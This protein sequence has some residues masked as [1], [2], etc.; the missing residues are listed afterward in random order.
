M[1]TAITL[2]N[3][4]GRWLVAQL[5]RMSV[6]LAILA[7]IVL[8]A[9]YVL[10]VKSPALRH[11]FWGLLLAKPL[12]TF[13]VAS[14]LSLYAFLW[15]P[16][17]EVFITQTPVSVQMERLPFEHPVPPVSMPDASSSIETPRP[18][19]PPFWRQI[20][21]YGLVSAI[22]MLVASV[23]GLRLLLGCAYVAFLRSTALTQR[24]GPLAELVAEAGSPLRMRRRVRIAT[25]RV[26]HGPVLAGIF[27][28][29]ILLPESMA[30]ALTPKQ[31]KL[32][33]TH[34]LA[35]AKR[36]DNLVLLVQ[37]L[38]EMF[39]F[40]HPVVWLC[41]WMMRR[42]A[43]AACDDM[44][45]SAYGD[46]D[47]AGAAAYADS[48]TRVA[49]MK[50]GITHRLLVNTFAAAESNFNRRIR[51]ILSGRR[52]RM[53][54]WLSVATGVALI[55]IG[56][57]GLPTVSSSPKDKSQE[58][59]AT[60]PQTEA[61]KL[62]AD[63]SSALQGP[64]KEVLLAKIRSQYTRIQNLRV[65]TRVDGHF[66]DGSKPDGSM[67]LTWG[68][69]GE[70]R[71]NSESDICPPGGKSNGQQRI[72]VWNGKMFSNYNSSSNTCYTIPPAE[73][74]KSPKVGA[75]SNY[76]YF[77]GELATE[78]TLVQLFDRIP[79]EKLI[80]QPD[81]SGQLFILSTEAAIPD[82][83]FSWL[84]DPDRGWVVKEVTVELPKPGKVGGYCVLF[85]EVVND[86]KEALPGI[87]LPT[88]STGTSC[89]FEE[90]TTYSAKTHVTR[91][92]VNDPETE[93]LFDF[94][95]PKDCKCYDGSAMVKGYYSIA[96]ITNGL[97]QQSK[98][99]AEGKP[100]EQASDQPPID[101]SAP[102]QT[103][104]DQVYSLKDGEVLKRI[105]PPF[106]PERMDWYRAEFPGQ[107][108]SSPEGPPLC[109]TMSWDKRMVGMTAT[110][111]CD[112]TTLMLEH[113]FQ[114]LTGLSLN[115]VMIPSD[116]LKLEVPGDWIVRDGA[117]TET[118]IKELAR[119]LH[120]ELNCDAQFTK[121]DM[122]REVIVASGAY[123][124]TP[125]P[126]VK[127]NKEI[128]LF[129]DVFDPNSGAG[130]S[131]GKTIPEFLRTFEDRIGQRIIDETT[132][133]A[134]KTEYI[135]FHP[136]KS[137]NAARAK[138]LAEKDGK[139]LERL[140]NLFLANVAKQT[141]FQFRIEQRSVPIW[142]FTRNG[143]TPAAT[144]A[145]SSREAANKPQE[146][147][148]VQ[149]PNDA[150]AS[151]R[152]AFDQVYS[153]KDGEVLKRIAPPFIPERME[154]YRAENPGQAASIPEGP[155]YLAIAWDKRIVRTTQ[156]FG[157][158]P[159]GPVILGEVFNTL[160]GLSLDYLEV[161]DGLLTLAI[162]G[163]WVVRHGA[164]TETILKELA[165]IL[166]DELNCD[167][168]FTNADMEREVIVASGTY[169][170][171]PFPDVKGN[172]EIHV[173]A[174]VFD[175]NSG[176]QTLSGTMTRDFLEN[177][178]KQAGQRI[179][180]ET[181]PSTDILKP[182]H[183]YPMQSLN[184]ARVKAVTEKDGKDLERLRGLL[185]ANVA[186][187]TGIRFTIE[188]RSVP[189][190]VLASSAVAP[191]RPN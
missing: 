171:T 30:G 156:S 133:S 127:G 188:R 31:L 18:E 153:L 178:E 103:A 17:P 99:P 135:R 62:P 95:P 180:N 88:A 92:D 29:V 75:F 70:K 48:L 39:F 185:L 68:L 116:L 96:T 179:V 60:S 78:E 9:L 149:A 20:D 141:G 160:T 126:D 57:L 101:A 53:T 94:A 173:F 4:S 130:S 145:Q 80:V 104:F 120:D 33:I 65:D 83:R 87:W 76:A 182:V 137:F 157:R 82:F 69:S 168:Q 191:H 183:F 144:S 148:S 159:E 11:L 90:K 177:L 132:P 35:H 13:L 113:V 174:D 63:L 32:V 155:R 146:Q 12:V 152:T 66:A 36:W 111:T 189:V 110:F 84:L 164:E 43:E 161:P 93:K 175:P 8:I 38:A 142:V 73:G 139:D 79:L 10:R 184:E 106:I 170:F 77:V 5:G 108:A 136:T 190:W 6:E 131:A 163:D 58:S 52:G 165:R 16:L 151:W 109:V 1:D 27:R 150:S 129:A 22:W 46:A 122:P 59:Q 105:A 37:R 98:L 67:D 158:M 49:E 41:G 107:A 26:A 97:Q 112:P 128:H 44:V 3:E 28:P 100:S 169:A 34:E 114:S 125:L 23:L 118:I 54:L 7:G 115:H 61:T 167:V 143:A 119:I 121:V 181:T 91:L 51:R 74:N 71:Y 154:W 56:V 162:P 72:A 134:D 19:T 172:E 14:P 45:I 138:A 47:G 81:S 21:R 40:F 102:W 186:K 140:R 86:I 124:F 25:T 15:P 42:E 85:R 24:D 176:G 89:D 55:L 187:Q 123:A 2:L 117:D 147:A 64:E 166:H 50:C